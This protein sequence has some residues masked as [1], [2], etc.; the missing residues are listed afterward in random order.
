MKKPSREVLMTV[1]GTPIGN[2]VVSRVM[3]PLN[4]SAGWMKLIGTVSIIYGVLTALTIIGLLLA[5][6][7]IW[8]GILTRKAA[9]QAQLAYA[10]GDEN[11]AIMSTD[12]LRTIF[13]IQGIIL[14]I[15]LI[16]SAVWVVIIIAAIFFASTSN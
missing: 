9:T 1:Q 14:L 8:L 5:W 11:A 15:G 16:F 7:P 6:L 4:V 12:S 13:K 10:S 2:P 3:G